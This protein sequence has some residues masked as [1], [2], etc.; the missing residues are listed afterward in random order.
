MWID[1]IRLILLNR[2]PGKSGI[3]VTVRKAETKGVTSIKPPQGFR[4]ASQ[5]EG[6]LPID[7]P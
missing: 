1:C 7:W 2:S 3:F 5:T 6:P 4:E